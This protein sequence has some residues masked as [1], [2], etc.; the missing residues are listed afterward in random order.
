MKLNRN[1]NITVHFTFKGKWQYHFLIV[2]AVEGQENEC[3]KMII[4]I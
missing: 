2:S 3:G 4:T 1:W